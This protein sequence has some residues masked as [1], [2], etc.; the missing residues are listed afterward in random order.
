MIGYV[1]WRIRNFIGVRSPR[2]VVGA[3]FR[4][5]RTQGISGLI[6]RVRYGLRQAS[7]SALP[8]ETPAPPHPWTQ[9]FAYSAAQSD[10]F[11]LDDDVLQ[12]NRQV[13]EAFDE[14]RGTVR[15]ATWFLPYFNHA[16]FGGVHTILRLMSFMKARHG[17]QH[18]LVVFDRHDV[19]DTE[20]R[21]AVT[22]AFPDL[23]DID[24]VL[25]VAGSVLYD[26]LPPTDFAVCTM[27]I[28][29]FPLARFNATKAKFYMVQD[30]EPAFY[31][32][33]TLYALAEATY[34]LGFAGIVNTPGLLDVYRSYGN[35]GVSFIPAVE[36]QGTPVA[37]PTQARDVSV[38]VVVYGRPGTERNA[39]EVIAAACRILKE[40]FGDRI[41]IVSAGEDFAPADLGLEGVLEN[42]GLLSSLSEVERLYRASDIGICFMLSKHPS[43]QPFEYLAAGAVPVVNHN[44]ATAWFLR[45]GENCL[46]VEPYPTQLANAVG[47]LIEDPAL[48]ERVAATGYRQVTATSWEEQFEQ[49]WQFVA[50]ATSGISV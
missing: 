26:E 29:A 4:I 14:R 37:K 50:G 6:A 22:A 7:G 45:D 10:F 38:Q 24:I 30:F 27:W 1:R 34:R 43:Y 12:A 23:Y 13:V 3:P 15:S 47:R 36:P 25:P 33:G 16:L 21:S 28:S 41:R 40:R 46:I 11:D 8:V 9:T 42:V 17:V 39:F 35:P 20:I 5:V 44:P 48:R 18:R 2:E 19:H 49:V 32:A 31:P